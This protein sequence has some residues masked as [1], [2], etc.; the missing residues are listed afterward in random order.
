M[1]EKARA[2]TMEKR[3]AV[4]CGFTVELWGDKHLQFVERM[5]KAGA[6]G[7][8]T[9]DASYKKRNKAKKKKQRKGAVQKKT[10]KTGRNAPKANKSRSKSRA[11]GKYRT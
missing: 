6:S 11:K 2:K 5:P 1:G 9:R 4:S 8:S 7:N 10:T 3:E